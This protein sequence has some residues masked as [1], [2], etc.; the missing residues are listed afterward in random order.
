MCVIRGKSLYMKSGLMKN[1]ARSHA[2]YILGYALDASPLVDSTRGLRDREKR[3]MRSC[4][5][6]THVG[7]R[8]PRSIYL[9]YSGACFSRNTTEA[10]TLGRPG[11]KLQLRC[12]G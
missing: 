9:R 2:C 6:M 5:C 11:P 4:H 10:L 8:A 7:C 3:K 12:L 1:D